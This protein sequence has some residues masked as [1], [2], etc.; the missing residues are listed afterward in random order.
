MSCF[1][2]TGRACHGERTSDE[3]TR[4]VDNESVRP[5]RSHT[6]DTP[7]RSLAHGRSLALPGLGTRGVPGGTAA[8]GG[9]D[10]PAHS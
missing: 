8:H 6:L 9:A 4:T 5:A 7:I 3:P 2:L 1:Q 10:P